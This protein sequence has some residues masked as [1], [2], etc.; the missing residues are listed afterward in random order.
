MCILRTIILLLYALPVAAQPSPRPVSVTTQVPQAD[1]DEEPRGPSELPHVPRKYVDGGPPDVRVTEP[2]I[3]PARPLP[4]ALSLEG[5]RGNPA[6]DPVEDLLVRSQKGVTLGKMIDELVDELAFQLSKQDPKILTPVAIRF[7]RLSPNL[8]PS[9]A[10]SLEAKVV[11]RL[12][13]LT[14]F[15]QVLCLECRA[16]RSRVEGD[17]WVVTL[18]AT[19]QADLRRIGDDI[20]ARTFMELDLNFNQVPTE[21]TLAAKIYR[22]SDGHIL[23]A[24]AI[25]GDET[26]AAVMRTGQKP[27]S[28]EEEL[29]ELNRK[30]ER[31]PYFGYLV[32]M[33][34]AYIGGDGPK[35]GYPS[36]NIMVRMY[37]RFAKERRHMYGIQAEGVF[38]WSGDHSMFGGIISAGYWYSILKP[39]L[40]HPDFRVGATAGAFIA[41]TDGNTGIFQV[42]LEYVLQFRMAFNVGALYMVPVKYSDGFDIG[43]FGGATRFAFNW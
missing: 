17:D 7:V 6:R 33:G 39:N 2:Q 28:R 41:G 19:T 21:V 1:D 9:L 3:A 14:N 25:K 16:V 37:E 31:R 12:A 8:R 40:N 32:A 11:S 24:S 10:Q 13:G 29:A 23:W 15:E 22:A 42:M 5:G 38:D 26:T 34:F 18:G 35:G 27:P 30:L 20:G 43:G 4:R 36:M